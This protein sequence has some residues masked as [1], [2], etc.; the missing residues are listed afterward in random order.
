[1]IPALEALHNRLPSRHPSWQF[2]RVFNLSN[3]IFV[4]NTYFSRQ[5]NH[6]EKIKVWIEKISDGMRHSRITTN[7]LRCHILFLILEVVLFTHL[8]LLCMWTTPSSGAFMVVIIRDHFNENLLLTY[9]NL[10]FWTATCT[11]KLALD[12]F[13]ACHQDI[14]LFVFRLSSIQRRTNT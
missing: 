13:L 4:Q 10:I 8:D 14:Y 9:A 2:M 3:V 7:T 1:M 6:I 5:H 12:I 11:K